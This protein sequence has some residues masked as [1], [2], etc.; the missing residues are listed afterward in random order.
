LLTELRTANASTKASDHLPRIDKTLFASQPLYAA[1][2]FPENSLHRGRQQQ[3]TEQSPQE[4]KQVPANDVKEK[5]QEA[6]E[7]YGV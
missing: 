3:Q 7:A 6:E 1:H 5:E 4:T 2:T